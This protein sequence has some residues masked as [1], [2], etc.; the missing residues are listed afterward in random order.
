M[1]FKKG[2][3]DRQTDRQTSGHER[4]RDLAMIHPREV[5]RD[6]QTDRQ[7]E[8]LGYEATADDDSYCLLLY[9]KNIA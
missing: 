8:R 2:Q 3:T 4:P 1:R 7:T 9:S 5:K 6:R